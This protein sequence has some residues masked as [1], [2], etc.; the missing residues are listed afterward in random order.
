MQDGAR[1]AQQLQAFS[2]RNDE[3]P[4][5]R[6][7]SLLGSISGRRSRA[8]TVSRAEPQTAATSSNHLAV[9]EV[10]GGRPA[11]V[12]S[13]TAYSSVEVTLPRHT[14]G[15]ATSAAPAK[16]LQPQAS[17]IL[18]RLWLTSAATFR[19]WGKMDE[20]LGAINEAEDV[21]GDK[22]PEVWLQVSPVISVRQNPGL[23]S[24]VLVRC[25]MLSI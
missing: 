3:A 5:G 12:Q 6:A 16:P 11:S 22:D 15:T 10:D 21:A 18:S 9:P 13:S 7:R 25:S 24:R 8:N 2:A 1:L 4:Q 23:T 14:N 19:R 20:C 17:R